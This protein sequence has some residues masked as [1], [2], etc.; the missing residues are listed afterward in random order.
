ML[1]C[2]GFLNECRILYSGADYIYFSPFELSSPLHFYMVF[3]PSP[4]YN[5]CI[6]LLLTMHTSFPLSVVQQEESLYKF[7]QRNI[8]PPAFLHRITSLSCFQT[9]QD[10]N[11]INFYLIFFNIFCMLSCYCFLKMLLHGHCC[12]K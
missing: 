7:L 4:N 8:V 11:I 1:L 2:W 9:T 12:S 10:K 3:C 5:S 6:F